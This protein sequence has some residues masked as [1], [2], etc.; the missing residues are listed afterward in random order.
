MFQE[1]PAQHCDLQH[2]AL[3]G[4]SVGVGGVTHLPGNGEAL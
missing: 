2:M 1:E 3:G 4:K